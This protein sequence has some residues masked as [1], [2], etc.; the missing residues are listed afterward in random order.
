MPPMFTVFHVGNHPEIQPAS[1]SRPQIAHGDAA[2]Y[3]RMEWSGFS[4]GMGR[5]RLFMWVGLIGARH[6]RRAR[7]GAASIVA[8]LDVLEW[9]AIAHH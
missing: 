4:S 5:G 1:V 6:C 2:L 7:H 8:V 9:V 3:V